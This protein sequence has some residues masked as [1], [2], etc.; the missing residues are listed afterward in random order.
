MAERA[1]TGRRR[2]EPAGLRQLPAGRRISVSADVAQLVER[3]LPKLE[4]AS[5]NLV[6]RFMKLRIG[7]ATIWSCL[8]LASV[9]AISGSSAT[10]Q[11]ETGW[12]RCGRSSYGGLYIYAK[13]VDCRKGRQVA[14]QA[15]EQLGECINGG[16]EAAGF[17]CRA[18]P[19]QVEGGN[20]VCSQ[21]KKRVR[22]G[23]GG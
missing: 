11:A 17:H 1:L 4:V 12:K 15:G 9:L 18:K 5:S 3:K 6:V 7:I 2:L 10:A 23:Y 16:C 22:F 19:N 20:I 13:K 21:G 14:Q 8:L